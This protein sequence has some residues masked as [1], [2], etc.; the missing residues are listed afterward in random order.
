MTTYKQVLQDKANAMKA[1][2]AEKREAAKS[3]GNGR[4]LKFMGQKFLELE[5]VW[6]QIHMLEIQAMLAQFQADAQI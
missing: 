2:A 5:A 3:L 4:R 6:D 1:E